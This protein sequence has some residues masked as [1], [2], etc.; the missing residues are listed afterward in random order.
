MSNGYILNMNTV[1]LEFVISDECFKSKSQNEAF[2]NMVCLELLV[3]Y[4]LQFDWIE[5]DQ[6]TEKH[7]VLVFRFHLVVL[8]FNVANVTKATHTFHCFVDGPNDKLV[9]KK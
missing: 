5:H 7:Y 3:F 4:S 2:Q 8:L 1:M 9:L 6:S